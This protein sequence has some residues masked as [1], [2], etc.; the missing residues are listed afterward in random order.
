MVGILRK[1]TTGNRLFPV[2]RAPTD[3]YNECLSQLFK[4]MNKRENG[5]T[6]GN[7]SRTPFSRIF[8]SSVLRYE[9]FN[10]V[11]ITDLTNYALSAINQSYET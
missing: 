9:K 6:E 3:G 7:L 1:P 10:R 11:D 8:L 5:P 2:A 4:D